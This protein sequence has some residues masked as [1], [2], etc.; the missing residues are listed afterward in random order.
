MRILE[1]CE[2]I[3][4]PMITE[5]ARDDSAIAEMQTQMEDVTLIKRLNG[6]LLLAHASHAEWSEK[7]SN[8]VTS[9]YAQAKAKGA[10][11]DGKAGGSNE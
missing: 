1:V 11:G 4:G 9:I 2:A 7:K 8:L 3:Y 10:K 6:E 5:T